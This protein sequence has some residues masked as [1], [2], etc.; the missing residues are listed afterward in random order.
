MSDV[1]TPLL[2]SICT[3]VSAQYNQG[4]QKVIQ[5][6]YMQSGYQVTVNQF[7]NGATSYGKVQ[8]TNTFGDE[9]W[10]IN[11]LG[12]SAIMVKQKKANLNLPNFG[13]CD[14]FSTQIQTNSLGF[15][16][17]WNW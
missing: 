2:L 17:K 13:V 10:M 8:E 3:G 16:W 15:N 9:T 4:C 6:A 5:S 11:T 12:A 1:F 7:Q 14:K